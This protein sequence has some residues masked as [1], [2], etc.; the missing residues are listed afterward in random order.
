LL[1]FA[2]ELSKFAALIGQIRQE[3]QDHSQ[4][5]TQH[6]V[7]ITHIERIFMKGRV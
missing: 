6:D 2:G 5:L 7:R 4:T 3:Q 1:K